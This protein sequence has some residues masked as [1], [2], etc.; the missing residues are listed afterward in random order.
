MA[1]LLYLLIFILMKVFQWDSWEACKNYFLEVLPPSRPETGPQGKTYYTQDLYPFI[2]HWQHHKKL[3]KQLLDD[4]NV[5]VD[6]HD[7]ITLSENYKKVLE[8][9]HIKNFNDNLNEFLDEFN[10][11]VYA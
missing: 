1:R 5:G 3:C 11:T 7:S 2:V 8:E 4:L 9:N 6:P 10:Y